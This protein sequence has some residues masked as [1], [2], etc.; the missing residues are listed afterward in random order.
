MPEL[1]LDV[2]EDQYR[3][4]TH[5][6]NPNQILRIQAGPG[7]GKTHTLVARVAYLLAQG[8]LPDQILILSMANKAVGNLQT[9]LSDLVGA[10]T[11]ARVHIATFHSFCGG[12]LDQYASQD[13]SSYT[14]T[15]VWDARSW[16]TVASFFASRLVRLGQAA[17]GGPVTPAR[18][19]QALLRVMAGS[20][21]ASEAAALGISP[22]Y[23]EAVVAHLRD[24]GVGSYDEIIRQAVSMMNGRQFPEPCRLSQYKM[25]FVDEFQ[26]ISPLLLDVIEAVVKYP[27]VDP[28]ADPPDSLEEMLPPDACTE[29][30]SIS[31]SH[32]PWKAHGSNCKHLTIAGDPDQCVY[33]FLG[34]LPEDMARIGDRFP[35]VPVVDV[36]LHDSFRCTQ[37]ILDTATACLGSDRKLTSVRDEAS[38]IKP[39]I[40]QCNSQGEEH[41]AIASEIQRLVA[42]LQH[43]ASFGDFA[44]LCRTNSSASEVQ[45]ALTRHGI[46]NQKIAQANAWVAS[47]LHVFRDIASVLSGSS[48]ASILL[49]LMLQ[50]LDQDRG[51]K[52]RL[53]KLFNAAAA[54]GDRRDPMFLEAYLYE[55][56]TGLGT[57]VSGLYKNYT[58]TLKDVAG[59]LNHIQHE[60]A[61]LQDPHGPDALVQSFRRI[62][63]LPKIT[64]YLEGQ[65]SPAGLESA[66]VTECLTSFNASLHHTYD[67]FLASDSS[68]LFVSYFL[69][70]Y[71]SEVP[72]AADGAV[73]VSTIHAAKGL[74]FPIV[75]ILGVLQ[76]SDMW[77]KTLGQHD[78]HPCRSLQ[79]TNKSHNS[80]SRLLYVALT[81]A[82]NLAYLG[83]RRLLEECSPGIQKVFTKGPVDVR[84]PG[85]EANA[86]ERPPAQATGSD[87]SP[88]PLNF[89]GLKYPNVQDIQLQHGQTHVMQRPRFLWSARPPDVA[90]GVNSITTESPAPSSFAIAGEQS[91]RSP[92]GHTASAWAMLRRDKNRVSRGA[93]QFS[94]LAKQRSFSL[95]GLVGVSALFCT[96]GAFWR[97]G[98]SFRLSGANWLFCRR[99]P[100]LGAS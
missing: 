71:N 33:D 12:L 93:R 62:A 34:V 67:Q 99:K 89:H 35:G 1:E 100:L 39:V 52:I 10:S 78:T 9:A 80:T 55:Q 5:G 79:A 26:D 65:S 40:L 64:R 88:R 58:L 70:A 22:Q 47:P 11:A 3:A 91:A 75:F 59:F 21:A 74:E 49:L 13:G 16:R 29:D 44:V 38:S 15:H 18:L 86:T 81:R 63:D 83:S 85:C 56:L 87:Q 61:R 36:F 92:Q 66:S 90:A 97:P 76:H 14:R 4:I 30:G 54:H 77:G 20:S 27:T 37:P 43:V 23:L 25:V 2:T 42:D 46:P 28:A 48:D 94:T 57:F 19:Q 84:P 98:A 73:K 51:A 82:R 68:Q 7:S 41:E 96:S 72:A 60:R 8:V 95:A 50:I 6:A 31:P 53:A 45:A 17:I 24:N 32:S 69:Q